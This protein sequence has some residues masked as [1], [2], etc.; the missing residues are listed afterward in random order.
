MKTIDE[1]LKKQSTITNKVKLWGFSD[2]H[3][4]EGLTS[5]ARNCLNI[6]VKREEATPN[7]NE[8]LL[9]LELQEVL[10]CRVIV[11][12]EENLTQEYKEKLKS[13]T[14]ALSDSI[15]LYALFKD[16][17]FNEP[18]SPQASPVT[19]QDYEY[20]YKTL[21]FIK[22]GLTQS[23]LERL[24]IEREPESNLNSSNNSGQHTTK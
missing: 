2:P 13:C 20:N 7:Y 10:G 6:L 15:G 3:L 22:E 4:F 23:A 17:T 24:K 5:G 12:Q 14:I 11:T 16:T 8:T 1:I 9:Q 19:K 21:S 18:I